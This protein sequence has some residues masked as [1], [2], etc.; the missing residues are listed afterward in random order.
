MAAAS[1]TL[2]STDTAKTK[3]TMTTAILNSILRLALILAL[4]GLSACAATPG[5][6]GTDRVIPERAQARWDALLAGDIETAYTYL[7]PGYR[8]TMSVVDYGISLSTRRVKW[9]SAE[10]LDHQCEEQRC[11]VSL[12]IGYSVAQ[13]MPGVKAYESF[14]VRDET[15]IYTDGQWWHL[16]KK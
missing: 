12:K 1:M 4:A 11:A 13:P 8:S 7:S 10:Y 5:N 6:Q 14:N 9:K 3:M 2:A 16:P 15:W